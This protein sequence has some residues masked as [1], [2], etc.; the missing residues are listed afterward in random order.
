VHPFEA[1]LHAKVARG[2]PVEIQLLAVH[3][4]TE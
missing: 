3:S 1:L 2:V 4:R